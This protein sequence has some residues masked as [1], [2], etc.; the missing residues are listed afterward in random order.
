MKLSDLFIKEAMDLSLKTT[1]KSETLAH[2]AGN[3]ASLGKV[4]DVDAYVAA[5]EAR[6][7]QST[8]GVG[9]E[10]AIPHAQHESQKLRLF[11]DVANKESSGNPSTDNLQNSS[12]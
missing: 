1:T 3:F 12:S 9:D 7:A 2:L 5:L 10:I 11:S 6:E 4:S 8:T